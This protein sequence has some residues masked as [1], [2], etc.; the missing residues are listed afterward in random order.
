MNPPRIR[1]LHVSALLLG[2]ILISG[3]SGNTPEQRVHRIMTDQMLTLATA[4]SCTGGSIAARFTA[5]PGASAYFKCGVVAYSIDA[6]NRL[7][8]VSCDTIARYGTVSEEVVRQMAD[9]IRRVAGTHY[10][11]A[12][13]GI[14]GPAGGTHETPVGTVWIAVS[15]PLGTTSQVIHAGGD[16]EQIIREAGTRAIELL[17]EVLTAE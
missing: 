16:R 15:S 6:K 1:T 3:C 10:G 5:Q 11:M 9:G 14:A 7:L 8:G 4:E 17:E 13:T 12:T 2:A